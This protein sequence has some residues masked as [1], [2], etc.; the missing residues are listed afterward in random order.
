MN[1]HD[2]FEKFS[3]KGFI[4]KKITPEDLEEWVKKQGDWKHWFQQAYKHYEKE[5]YSDA[6]MYCIFSLSLN[7]R[8]GNIFSWAVL[9]AAL[10]E[11]GCHDKCIMVL[12]ETLKLHPQQEIALLNLLAGQ[13]IK[14]GD[15]DTAMKYCELIINKDPSVSGAW[16]IKGNMHRKK[17][18]LGEAMDSYG[19]AIRL[20]NM[21]AAAWNNRGEVNMKKQELDDAERDFRQTLV[22]DSKHQHGLLNLAE[23]L[24]K[25]GKEEESLKYYRKVCKL[26]PPVSG[27]KITLDELKQQSL[28]LI[29]LHNMGMLT[30]RIDAKKEGEYNM[31]K[32]KLNA[33]Y[34]VGIGGWIV[35]GLSILLCTLK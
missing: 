2:L 28:S 16:V 17:N 7:Y 21:N 23:V 3:P 5:E 8:D 31:E 10:D 22:A 34:I 12:E 1:I 9:A 13:W 32:Q 35:G 30:G 14:K 29:A 25:L 27:E 18:E 11:L 20:D 4:F 19:E 26:Y 24:E 33:T 6:M 15:E